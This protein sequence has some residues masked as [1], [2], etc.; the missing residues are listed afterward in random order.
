MT[1]DAEAL[2][3]LCLRR[4]P[5]LVEQAGGDVDADAVGDLAPERDAAAPFDFFH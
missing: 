1:V 5:R 2:R 4:Q 3:Q